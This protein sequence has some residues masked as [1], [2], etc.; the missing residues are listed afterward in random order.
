MYR[1]LLVPGT[2]CEFYMPYREIGSKTH[3]D[4]RTC[5]FLYGDN[6]GGGA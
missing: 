1:D 4:I 2:T 6:K 5:D 3:F